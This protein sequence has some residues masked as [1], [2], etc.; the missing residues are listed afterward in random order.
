MRGQLAA[1]KSPAI[2]PSQFSWQ[3]SDARPSPADG[4]TADATRLQRVGQAAQQTVKPG[5]MSDQLCQ[6]L[7]SALHDETTSSV[8]ADAAASEQIVPGSP[9]QEALQQTLLQW[10]PLLHPILPEHSQLIR[11][12]GLIVVSDLQRT[13]FGSIHPVGFLVEEAAL[14]PTDLL[15]S[16]SAGSGLLSQIQP[17]HSTDSTRSTL[18]GDV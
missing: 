12:H 7:P 13:P 8:E 16:C 3:L 4:Q 10:I 14:L 5:A 1:C 6:S 17:A 11:P 9:R 2:R 15:Q 18:P